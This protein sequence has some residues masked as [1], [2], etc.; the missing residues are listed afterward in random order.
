MYF[1]FNI[2][3]PCALMVALSMFSFLLHPES[4]EKVSLNVTLFLSQSVMLLVL[5]EYMPVQSLEIPAL[6]EYVIL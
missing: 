6:C 2:F 4:G 3:L 1:I 5:T